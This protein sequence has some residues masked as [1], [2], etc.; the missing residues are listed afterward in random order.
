MSNN[1]LVSMRLMK[2]HTKNNPKLESLYKTAKQVIEAFRLPAFYEVSNHCN[3]KCEGCYYFDSD[4]YKPHLHNKK[5]Y[6]SE[7]EAFLQNEVDK[8]VTMPYFLGAEPAMEEHRL[9]T[10]SKYFKRGNIGTNGTIHLDPEIQFR[11]SI[12]AWSAS[13]EDDIKLRGKSA[14]SKAL[15]LYRNDPRAIVLYTLNKQNI[16][17]AKDI[18]KMCQEHGL[19]ITFNLW[20]PTYN[21]IA[22]L[23]NF[24]GNDKNFFRIS[25]PEESLRFLDEDLRQVRDTLDQLID[26]Y[27]ETVIYSHAYNHWSTKPGSLYELDNNNVAKNCGSR[28]T[29]PFKY[30][31]MDLEPQAMKCCT[32]AI[33]CRECRLYSGGM[34]S[35]F[36]PTPEQVQTI[37]GFTEWLDIILT[38]GRIFLRPETDPKAFVSHEAITNILP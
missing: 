4:T 30:Y 34:S 25:T 32:T 11:I 5:K 27:P 10:A 36:L 37:Q 13:E 33:D 15:T 1:P 20:S 26:D 29:D 2:M 7:W 28:I 3:L 35:H 22:R 17:Q 21:L 8:G 16:S 23:N 6:N 14:L 12:S 24:T 18:T 9:I 38:I 19:P 31:G